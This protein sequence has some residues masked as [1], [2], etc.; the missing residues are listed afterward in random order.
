MNVRNK[1]VKALATRNKESYIQAVNN[2][3]GFKGSGT[4]IFTSP[5]VEG[6]AQPTTASQ[7]K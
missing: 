7:K 5:Y 3:F 4:Y 2:R 1:I 6:K